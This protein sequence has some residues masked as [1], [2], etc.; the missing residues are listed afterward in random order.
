MGSSNW[1]ENG[2]ID[3]NLAGN[4]ANWL[5]IDGKPVKINRNLAEATQLIQTRSKSIP[6]NLN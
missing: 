5:K 3:L 6:A 2:L 4:Y 1:S